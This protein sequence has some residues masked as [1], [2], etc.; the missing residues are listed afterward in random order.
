MF[1]TS[2]LGTQ[3]IF[4]QGN[5]FDWFGWSWLMFGLLIAVIVALPCFVIWELGER[6]PVLDI[7]L[8]GQRNYAVAA[9]CSM[10]GFLSIQGL[11]SIFVT[12]AQLLLGY[13]SSLAGLI[14]MA[15][16]SLSVPLVSMAHKL[17]EGNDA[18]FVA[19]LNLLGLSF[20]M[21]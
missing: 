16:I 5:D 7:R 2:L 12:Q 1:L 21:L 11:F 8:F 15:M 3:T 17:C 6:H 9:I 10:L 19:S 13:S 20:M 4:N 14:F 18:R